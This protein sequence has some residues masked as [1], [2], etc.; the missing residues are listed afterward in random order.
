MKKWISY[1]LKM[2][3]IALPIWTILYSVIIFIGKIAFSVKGSTF[4]YGSIWG[5]NLHYIGY[6]MILSFVID[7]LNAY[8]KMVKETIDDDFKWDGY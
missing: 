6:I 1:I 7:L 8:F 3:F 2:I 4:D 5:N